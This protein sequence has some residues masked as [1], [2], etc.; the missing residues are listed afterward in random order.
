V[1]DKE[2]FHHT[3][4]TFLDQRRVGAHAQALGNV[5]GA[6]NLRTRHPID[7][8]FAVLA[9]RR[10]AIRAHSRHAHFDQAHATVAWGGE[11]LV[12]AIARHIT[13]GL[14]ASLDQTS[15]LGE[16]VPDAV[17]LDVDHWKRRSDLGH[18]RN[19]FGNQEARN[20]KEMSSS[21]G[22]E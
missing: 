17:D 20:Q 15:A 7:L 4:A 19:Q 16:L 3:T 18:E 10:F 22:R 14:L 8:R 13:A 11:L 21:I 2:K 12:V 1:I 9:E 6:A 5:G